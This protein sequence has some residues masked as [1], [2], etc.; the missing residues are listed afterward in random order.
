M[1]KHNVILNIFQLLCYVVIIYFLWL[2][3]IT[4]LHAVIIIVCLVV[5]DVFSSAQGKREQE[6]K[7]AKK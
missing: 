6:L 5:L 2:N 3:H 7:D 1:D 4:L